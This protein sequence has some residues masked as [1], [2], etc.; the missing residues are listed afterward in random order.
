[1]SIR[2]SEVKRWEGKIEGRERENH[3]AADA[4]ADE[5]DKR[6]RERRNSKVESI[7]A[8]RSRM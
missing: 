8:R 1:M 3:E 7:E 5:G 6:E 4:D 2:C